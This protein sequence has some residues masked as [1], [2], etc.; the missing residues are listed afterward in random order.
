LAQS[1]RHGVGGM[2]IID[3]GALDGP[4]ETLVQSLWKA[5]ANGKKGGYCIREGESLDIMDW[6]TVQAK[7]RGIASALIADGVEAGDRVAI[8]AETSRNWK[9]LDHAIHA[10]GAIVVPIY[11]TLPPDLVAHILADS[12]SKVLFVQ[13]KEQAA[14]VPTNFAPPQYCLETTRGMKSIAKFRPIKKSNSVDVTVENQSL[15]SS[16]LLVYTSGTTGVPKGVLLTHRNVAGDVAGAIQSLEL[17]KI[18]QPKLVAFLPLAHIAGYVSLAAM[19]NLDAKVLFSRPDRMGPDL[20][21]FHPTIALAVPRLWERIVRKVEEAVSEGSPIKQGLFARAKKVAMLAGQQM[22]NGGKIRGS[23]KIKHAFYERLIYSKL[24]HKLGFD[25][26]QAGITGAAAIRPDLLWFLQGIGLPIV[27]GYGMT[28]SSALSVGTRFHAWKAGTVGTPLP[29]HKIRLD[30]DGEILIGGIGVFQEYW[31]LPAET[32]ETR[33]ML[34]GE[35]WIRSGDIG[36]IDNDGNLSIVDRKKELEILDTGKM[37]A[38]VRVE[39][40]LKSETSLVE[41]SCLVANGKK[42]AVLLIQPAYDALL[43][44]AEKLGVEINENQIVRKPAPTGE[45]QTYS[46]SDDILDHPKIIA[47]FDDALERLN[48]RLADYERV[49]R[50]DLVPDA[51]TI[52]RDELTPSFKKRRR[53]IVAHYKDRLESMFNGPRSQKEPEIVVAA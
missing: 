49:R 27:E 48:L 9:I 14:K 26:L 13:N 42:F 41:D 11:P 34:D 3:G 5:A 18:A 52:E 12:G 8:L 29:G 33:V 46:V 25:E 36:T 4:H 50:F 37:I 28:E 2:V 24:R 22:D 30:T 51:F 39:E 1:L 31:K 20:A 43:K 16:A 38:P 40:L 10:V 7:V 17:H 15:D 32:K 45:M 53:D 6:P 44:A 21:W 23:L 35:P 19:V 47:I